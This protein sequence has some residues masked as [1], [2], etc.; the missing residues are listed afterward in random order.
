MLGRPRLVLVERLFSA[1]FLVFVPN[2]HSVQ[3]QSRQSL[4]V[5]AKFGNFLEAKKKHF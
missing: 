3:A 1:P 4:Q 2:I 5:A